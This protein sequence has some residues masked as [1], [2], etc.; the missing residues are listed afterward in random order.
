MYGDD[1]KYHS[2]CEQSP[3]NSSLLNV[4]EII[5]QNT[6]RGHVWVFIGQVTIIFFSIQ[7][8]IAVLQEALGFGTHKWEVDTCVQSNSELCR[9][10]TASQDVFLLVMRT[11]Y[12]NKC[13]I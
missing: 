10:K 4:L 8:K 5:E 2:M 12:E 7:T 6:S 3:Q 9:G 1:Y 11:S 13:V